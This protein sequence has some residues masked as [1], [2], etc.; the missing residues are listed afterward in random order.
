MCGICGIYHFDNLRGVQPSSLKAM[1]H[2]IRHRGPDDQGEYFDG[3]VGLGH[4]RLSI[5]DLSKAAH[6]PMSTEDGRFWIIFNGEIYNYQELRQPLVQRGH[7]L[8]SNSDTE[9]ILHLYQDEGP[10]CVNKLNG[11]FAFVIW[12]S[13]ERTL[14]VAR[15]HFGIKPFYYA[16]HDRTFLF[17]S[18]IKSLFFYPGFEP[19]INSD[20]LADYLTFQFCLEEK[21]L[22]R[23]VQKLPPG[24]TLLVKADGSLNIHKYWDLDFQ[25]DTDHTEDYFQSQL[26][27][28]LEDSVRLQL[29]A[30]VPV[31]AHLSGGLDSSTLACL[32]SSL[33][34]TN[35]HTFSGGFRDD[36]KYDETQYA[37]LVTQHIGSDYHEIYPTAQDFVAV[38]PSLIYQMDEPAAGPGV[39]PQYFVSKLASQ[40]VKVVLGGQGGDEIFGGYSRYLVAYLEECIRGGIEGTQENAKYVVTFAS[41]LPNLIQLQGYQPMLSHFWQDGLFN[42]PD[43]RY[44]RLI[45]R[46]H[47][48]RAFVDSS[49]M[50]GSS[51]YDP[52]EAY[53]ELFNA[54]Q[55]GSYINR[56]TRFDLKTLLP[57][58]LQVE[59]RTSMAVSLESRVPLLD[60]RIAKLA[61][62][63][64]PNIKFKGGHSKHIFRQVVRHIVP[65]E[66]LER[67]DKMGFPVPLNEWYLQNPVREFVQETLVSLRARRGGFLDATPVETLLDAERSFGRNIWGLLCLELWMQAY[68]DGKF[69]DLSVI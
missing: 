43:L 69:R 12:D 64:P 62:S 63:M 48:V 40:H 54:G 58:L 67:K 57:A 30:D 20:G 10:S 3:P 9:V 39:F 52:V 5:I 17:A 29:R 45:D 18:E 61:A 60:P 51:G 65:A 27:R 56:M 36:L 14:F 22:F 2:A 59:D 15:D 8:R 41:I 44:F 42:S 32:A 47:D 28:L 68:I 24:H 11:M 21:T 37:R 23:G 34:N 1:A 16:I 25:I 50:R 55:I 33:L 6:Q 19:E 38:M 49:L 26:L 35:I 7:N 31:G 4:K 53:R 46:S 66:I 13:V